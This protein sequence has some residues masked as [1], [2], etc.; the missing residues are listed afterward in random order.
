[1]ASG[2]ARDGGLRGAR[3]MVGAPVG[4]PEAATTSFGAATTSFGDLTTSFGAA[5]TRFFV[6]LGS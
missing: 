5:T 3:G 1:M 4:A 6:E 2:G